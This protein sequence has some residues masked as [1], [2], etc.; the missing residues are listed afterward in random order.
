MAQPQQHDQHQQQQPMQQQQ[1]QQQDLS[2][3]V[4]ELRSARI[5]QSSRLQYQRS[6]IKFIQ[7]IFKNKRYLLSD[8]FLSGV[9][10]SQENL[11]KEYVA[12][13][14][15]PPTDLQRPPIKFDV[16]VADDFLQWISS[17]KK[18]DDSSLGVSVLSG[19]RSAFYNLYKDFRIQMPRQ[20]EDDLQTTFQGIKRIKCLELQQGLRAISTLLSLC[21]CSC[22][23]IQ[24]KAMPK[25]A[26]IRYHSQ[27][28]SGSAASCTLHCPTV[29][30]GRK[31][32]S[33]TAS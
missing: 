16:I 14:L 1:P 24:E 8:S 31:L 6:S 3:A 18:A 11:S 22:V 17:L 27:R 12:S 23:F 4:E 29:A 32:S 9:D 7:W 26:R 5:A 10:A 25:L 21:F 13:V 33:R 15:G 20:M 19:H 2:A 28:T 30:L